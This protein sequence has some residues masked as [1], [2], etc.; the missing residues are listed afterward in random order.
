VDHRDRAQR[1]RLTGAV[2]TDQRDDLALVDREVDALDRLDNAVA[3][4]NV[5]ELE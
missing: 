5:L 2:A 4:A 3:D 1:G